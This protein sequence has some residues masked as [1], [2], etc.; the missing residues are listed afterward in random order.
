MA[1]W[2]I[3]DPSSLIAEPK[4]ETV[5]ENI[6]AIGYDGK[7]A[8]FKHNN[9]EKAYGCLIYATGSVRNF[10]TAEELDRFIK[11][12]YPDSALPELM[13]LENFYKLMWQAIEKIKQTDPQKLAY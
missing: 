5:V 6:S 12:N 10:A 8:V 2:K 11:L 4:C 7:F 3:Y 1:L 9:T 13:K